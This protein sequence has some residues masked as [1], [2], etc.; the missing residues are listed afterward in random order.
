[1]LIGDMSGGTMRDRAET[2]FSSGSH[3]RCADCTVFAD[4]PIRDAWNS[5]SGCD[6]RATSRVLEKGEHAF[7]TGD[8]ADC[9]HFLKSG[10]LKA[11]VLSPA[12]EE[13]VVAFY[14]PGDLVGIESMEV[15]RQTLSVEALSLCRVCA[16]PCGELT[17][18]CARSR[19][20][21]RRLL[22]HTGRRLRCDSSMFALIGRR[23]AEQRVT[24]FLLELALRLSD[25]GA[26]ALEFELKM[27]RAD[28]AS[29]LALAV[30]TVS[31]VMTRLQDSGV[32]GVER[33]RRV[34]VLDPDAMEAVVGD[35]PTEPTLWSAA[36]L[37]RDA[38]NSRGPPHP[39]RA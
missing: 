31:R 11:Y 19:P 24:A 29:Y 33:N 9:V 20:I 30:E 14:F 36:G 8:P 6:V 2:P 10:A 16:L 28:I 21:L 39:S 1:M 13:Q 27:T 26:P 5:E 35:P 25:R 18:L 15:P 23:N 3:E 32:I 12:G 37:R 38:G 4:C 7:R 34:C 17:D 22:E